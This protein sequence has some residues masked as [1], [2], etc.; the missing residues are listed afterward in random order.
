MYYTVITQNVDTRPI[1]ELSNI[2]NKYCI[3]IK[4]LFMKC[5]KCI[6]L[7]I[8]S[9][10]IIRQAKFIIA[11]ETICIIIIH[12]KCIIIILTIQC[13]SHQPNITYCTITEKLPKIK[14]LLLC[15]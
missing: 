11:K 12:T 7:S 9:N 15:I 6:L 4:Y 14:G 8:K 1:V 13:P 10:V 5:S 3:E 2:L